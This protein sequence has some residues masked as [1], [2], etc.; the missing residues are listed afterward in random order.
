MFVESIKARNF[1]SFR[2]LAVDFN[3]LNIFI[4]ANAAGKSSFVRL[5]AFI[6]DIFLYGLEDAVS[7][8][9]G[10]AYMRNL[11]IGSNQPF[12]LELVLSAGGKGEPMVGEFGGRELFYQAEEIRYQFTLDF[13]G[14]KDN[15][16][17]EIGDDVLE[18][19]FVFSNCEN[20]GS[21]NKR[22]NLT[23]TGDGDGFRA[24]LKAAGV[25]VGKEDFI[26]SSYGR[27]AIQ[28]GELLLQKPLIYTIVP[29][30]E[31]FLRG[32]SL[33]NFDPNI[34]RGASAV[35]G[36]A[37]LEKDG[38][39]LPLVLKNIL[40]RKESRRKL[41][42]LMR[43]IL[44]FVRDMKVDRFTEHSLVFKLQEV[45]AEGEYIPAS[46]LSD[47]TINV[48]A[49]IVALYFVDNRVAL[50]EEPER[51]IHP[52]LISRVVEMFYDAA[53]DKQVFA[54]THNP[55]MVKFLD[56]HNLFLVQRSDKGFSSI[57]KPI[58]REEVKI[59]LR[60]DMGIDELYIQNLLEV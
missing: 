19:K 57:I 4:G 45:F 46:L 36:R 11:K 54:T 18:I 55:E 31:N 33:Y 58:E 26:P 50:F 20:G 6:R 17:Y 15:L 12:E 8:Q 39:N 22:A 41:I 14:T 35:S 42:N 3:D 38:S 34:T 27:Q 43:D 47:G 51:N 23:L 30:L 48:T 32:I 24:D 52:H 1:K 9:G 21:W 49:L 40:D 2:E 25:K 7:L 60:Q 13:F 53:R 29:A 59:F 28:E 37:G 16:A 10:I 44:P 56:L 5:F